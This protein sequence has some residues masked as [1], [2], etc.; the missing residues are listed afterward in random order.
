MKTYELKSVFPAWH[1]EPATVR[2]LKV[3]GFFGKDISLPLTK[4]VCS[5]IIGR[6]FSDPANKHLWTA[7]VYTTGDEDDLSTDLH[8]HDKAVLARTVIP[9]DW[10][11]KRGPS[12]PSQTQKA[13]E[14][15]VGEV[16]KDGSPF[17]DPLPNVKIVGTAFCFTGVFEFG[18]RN[19]CQAAVT[20]RGGTVTPRI[21]HNTDVLVVGN[22]PNPA[23]SHGGYGNKI[24]EAMVLKLHRLKPIIIPELY[25]RALLNEVTGNAAPVN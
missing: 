10:Q 9:A 14:R 13:L 8:A 21:N 16:L 19:E 3:L 11:P 2:Q 23:W 22:D 5:G 7:Y 20:S 25:W 24:L 4:G 12:I 6:L 15:L 18:T 1:F 17:D